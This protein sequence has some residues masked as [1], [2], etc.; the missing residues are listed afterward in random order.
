MVIVETGIPD[1][2]P[3]LAETIKV[4][5][6]VIATFADGIDDMPGWCQESAR[7]LVTM[8]AMDIECLLDQHFERHGGK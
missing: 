6:G 5:A 3:D 2:D 7:R 1:I 4:I 8:A